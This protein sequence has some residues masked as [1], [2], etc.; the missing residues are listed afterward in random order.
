MK[1]VG[2]K[3]GGNWDGRFRGG[4]LGNLIFDCLIR[5]GGVNAA[6]VLLSFVV[7]YFIPAA[8]KATSSIWYYN[9]RIM[10]YGFF[11]SMMMLYFH[12]F[13]FGQ[14]LIDKVAIA[15][16]RNKE[17]RFDTKDRTEFIKSFQNFK[18]NGCVFISAH[19][20]SWESGVHFFGQ[21]GKKINVVMF[22][23]ASSQ[24]QHI[25]GDHKILSLSEDPIENILKIKSVLD[26]HEYVCFQGDRFIEGQRTLK[27]SF[28]GEEAEFPLG[29]FLFSTRL[30]VPVVFY[31]SM[32][33]PKKGY[34]FYLRMAGP[35]SESRH[36]P[37]Q[38]QL[39]DQYIGILE[40][41]VRQYPQQ[42]F[43]FY[44]FWVGQRS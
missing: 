1:N 26:A 6:Y 34:R 23:A 31:F 27:V 11:K 44:P 37:P 13:S 38:K 8:P 30:K 39:L 4:Y 29:P 35:V 42:W 40:K 43:N 36:E 18:D 5:Y 12:Y 20:G 41:I 16:G 21:E 14:V 19:I 9:R 28:M 7:V 10:H 15:Q 2:S 32:R 24:E 33:L 3:K 22:N 25:S 17:Y